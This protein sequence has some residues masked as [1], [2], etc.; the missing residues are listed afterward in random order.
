MKSIRMV[1][2]PS[3]KGT[4]RAGLKIPES[5]GCHIK[6]PSPSMALDA[7]LPRRGAA[8][9]RDPDAEPQQGRELL[10]KVARLLGDKMTE[11][12]VAEL[13]RL[14]ELLPEKTFDEA[15]VNENWREDARRFLRER[16]FGEDDIEH[17]FNMPANAME[18]GMGGRTAVPIATDS[19]LRRFGDDLRRLTAPVYRSEGRKPPPAKAKA[20]ALD[21]TVPATTTTR[22]ALDAATNDRLRRLT[23]GLRE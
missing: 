15:P 22:K 21:A 23:A 17:F 12:E 11:R 4:N 8:H 16:G 7:A 2:A 10:L 13:K 3:P 18:G 14:Y 5:W 6:K 9:D 19:A 20:L 1:D